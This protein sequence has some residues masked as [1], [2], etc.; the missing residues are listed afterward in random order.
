M[1]HQGACVTPTGK[2]RAQIFLFPKTTHLSSRPSLFFVVH[3]SMSVSHEKSDKILVKA[4]HLFTLHLLPASVCGRGYANICHAF[5]VKG[6]IFS[7]ND[8]FKCICVKCMPKQFDYKTRLMSCALWQE[9]ALIW[10]KLAPQYALKKSLM[11]QKK[12]PSCW[13]F[14]EVVCC[15]LRQVPVPCTIASQFTCSGYTQSNY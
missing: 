6:N 8:W 14:P 3:C 12:I 1:K 4:C 15:R 5:S 2:F 11:R 9:W 7:D 13:M 10:N